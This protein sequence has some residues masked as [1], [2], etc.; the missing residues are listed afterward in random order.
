MTTILTEV[1][2]WQHH[3]VGQED[4]VRYITLIDYKPDPVLLVLSGM[5]ENS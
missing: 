2:E 3:A 1:W 4:L 5:D